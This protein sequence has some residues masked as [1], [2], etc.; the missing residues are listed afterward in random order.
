M[1]QIVGSCRKFVPWRPSR[2]SVSGR[3]L[4]T[5]KFHNIGEF[6]L[7]DGKVN[8]KKNEAWAERVKQ[9]ERE[10]VLDDRTEAEKWKDYIRESATPLNGC[11][12]L[13]VIC[14]G[15]I[16]Y[17]AKQHYKRRWQSR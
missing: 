5:S 4:S 2:P 12:A 3:Y 7:Y 16:W 10:R 8:A 9:L 6:T 17:S 1:N 13:S 15:T 14:M 11:L